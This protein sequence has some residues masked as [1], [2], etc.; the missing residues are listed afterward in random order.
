M[1]RTLRRSVLLDL[2]A[3]VVA[4][5]LVV[6]TGILSRTMGSDLRATCLATAVA[7][8]VA[9]LL[10]GVGGVGNVWLKGLLV[11]C[12]GL[13]G[14]A[15]LIMNNGFHRLSVP[16]ALAFL[17]VLLAVAGIRVRRLWTI[18][19]RA[20]WALGLVSLAGATAA[21]FAL[22]P[23]L[24]VYASLEHGGRSAPSYTLTTFDG[25]TV[26]SSELQGRVVMLAFWASWCLPCT[27]EL[28][29]LE[30]VYQHFRGNPAVVLLA[31]DIGWSGETA[32]RGKRY[33]DRRGLQIPGAFDNGEAARAF[34]VDALPTLVL[35]DQSGRSRVTH[36]GYD[37]SEHL[38]S[39]LTSD[40]EALLR[41]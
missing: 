2:A 14:T 39:L 6:G 1:E 31:V 9:G 27:W 32:V 17:A 10:R 16:V 13:L 20:S 21:V 5:T 18:S 12:G 19:R 33:L 3:G 28:P 38:D 22:V 15:A 4:I 24:A 40:I 11:S 25:R 26:R 34:G 30:R 35:I 41:Q 7:F 29:E 37:A 36:F 8:F 23:A